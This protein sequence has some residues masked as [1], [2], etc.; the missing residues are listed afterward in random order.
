MPLTNSSS[1]SR[2]APTFFTS[3][4]VRRLAVWRYDANSAPRQ[5]R[6]WSWLYAMLF[7]LFRSG[8]KLNMNKDCV[9]PGL[10]LHCLFMQSCRP[11]EAYGLRACV[12]AFL[13]TQLYHPDIGSPV[14][15]PASYPR[16]ANRPKNLCYHFD[17][18][19]FVLWTP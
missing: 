7:H 12:S 6:C 11:R 10:R 3:A 4:N 8:S 16:A 2:S 9:N 18:I 19:I 15:L 1:E 5:R 17:A 13:T 14:A